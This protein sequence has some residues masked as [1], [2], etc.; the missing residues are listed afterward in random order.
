MSYSSELTKERILTCAKVEFLKNGFIN[1]NLREIAKNAKVTTG[2]LYNYFD[3]KDALFEAIVGEFA[4]N[5]LK[6][7]KK[8]HKE[9]EEQYDFESADIT[10]NMGQGTKIVLEYLYS[11]FELSKLLFCASA[12]TKYEKFVDELIDIEEK[13]SLLYMESIN[14][15]LKKINRFFVHVISTSG[16]NNMLEAIH[17]DL[18]REEAIEYI[19]KIQK[20]YYK[21]TKEILGQ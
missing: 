19:G 12:N 10:E 7:Y 18:S 14:F 2:A 9:A 11:N 5:L 6:L 4:D 16:L 13:A 1:T 21:G 3:G 15:E 17:H 20:F 8:V